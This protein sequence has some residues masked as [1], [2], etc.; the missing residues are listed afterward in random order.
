MC[1]NGWFYPFG[2]PECWLRLDFLTLHPDLHRTHGKG[3]RKTK[4]IRNEID[5]T[6]HRTRMSCGI[7]RQEGHNRRPCPQSDLLRT[8]RTL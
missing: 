2:V 4:R 8:K 5:F 7:C 6:K 3:P 1:Y